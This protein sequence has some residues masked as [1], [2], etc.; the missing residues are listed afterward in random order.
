MIKVLIILSLL[1]FSILH[2]E[3]NPEVLNNK[4]FS[5][6][7]EESKGYI[8]V[9]FFAYTCGSCSRMTSVVNSL[10]KDNKGFTTYKLNVDESITTKLKYNVHWI[11]CFIIFKD[12]KE[13]DRHT[14]IH[15]KET[16]EQWMK[17]AKEK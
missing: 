3:D 11:P 17:E 10:F 5:T 9:D 4:T 6:K 12:G 2:A 14:G 15:T 7:V 1:S 8:I 16:L 13:V